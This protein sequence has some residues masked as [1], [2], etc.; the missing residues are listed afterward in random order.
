MM[1]KRVSAHV[2]KDKKGVK[3]LQE[4][5]VHRLKMAPLGFDV[6]KIIFSEL[7]ITSNKF[8][9]LIENMLKIDDI[10]KELKENGW[11]LLNSENL[12]KLITILK[13]AL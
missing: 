11:Q 10:L 13:E 2:K 4:T 6:R 12:H 1:D 5:L 3:S 9:V 7:Q 8:E